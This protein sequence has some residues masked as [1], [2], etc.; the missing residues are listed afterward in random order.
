MSGG[1]SPQPRNPPSASQ[2][3]PSDP[4]SRHMSSR[5][6]N[7][8]HPPISQN[9]SGK[10]TGN[11]Q[12]QIMGPVAPGPRIE[13]PRS[14]PGKQSEFTNTAHVPCKFFRQGACQAGKACPF[15]HD[16]ASTTDN[17]C[18]YFA[19]GNCKFGPKCANIHVLP[20][21]QRVNYHKGG[22]GIGGGHLNIG[23]RVNP[24]A[25]H[26]Q[27]SA[28]TNSLYRANMIPPS[29]FGQ[30]Y[31]PFP[32]Q[33]ESFPQLGRRASMD[34]GVPAI[35]TNY[36]S[37]P[38]SAYGSPRDDDLQTRMGLGL[39]AVPTKGLSVLDV[40]LP[41]S[42]DSNGV[43]WIARHGPVAASVPSQFG[44]ESPP[45]SLGMS[46]DGRTSEALKNLHSSAFGDDTRDRF[47]GI[48]AS[49]P[50][51]LADE[52]FGKRVMH[53]QRFAKQKI[54]SSSLPKSGL[55]IDKDWEADFT[56]EEDYLPDNLKELLTPQ[57]KARRDSRNA[58]EEGR[59]IHS[60]SG[61]PADSSKLG[62][63][64]NASPSRWGPLFQRQQREEE[65]KASRTSAFGHVGSPLRNSSLKVESLSNQRSVGRTTSGSGD[66]SPF[67]ASPPRQSS[68][69]IISQ[70]L[71]RTR[72]SRA[73]SSGSE[74]SLHPAGSRLTSNPIGSARRADIDRQISSS[75]LGTNRFTTPI[76]EEQA[77]FVF[78]MEEEEDK[79]RER[80]K[81][82]SGG[83]AWSYASA[84][85]NENGTNGAT[86]ATRASGTDGMFAMGR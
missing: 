17:V 26:G 3:S 66:G 42:F 11:G 25:Y 75:S 78:R 60:G 10:S 20:N 36:A 76:D 34:M 35:D 9:G 56:F 32:N 67:L 8:P 46:K 33:D 44:L 28:L 52:Y 19:K 1:A 72:L 37:H 7:I 40:P 62:S 22:L 86:T 69:S 27:S 39:S 5:S 50:A 4:P 49:P 38:G 79:E 15:S 2:E 63:P 21:G 61:T 14:P 68:M 71:Q 59:P 82:Y 57:E 18:K 65:E 24:D 6:L 51:P 23:G 12:P 81:R 16:L 30:P 73:E 83:S 29:P 54:M 55:A 45:Q 64:S 77:E 47:N 43:S 84:A 58:D 53:S 41:A 48:A 80:E 13:G 70:Q 31:S 74:T 85:R